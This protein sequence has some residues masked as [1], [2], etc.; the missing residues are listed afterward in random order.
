[1]LLFSDKIVTVQSE[2]KVK[3]LVRQAYKI[4]RPDGRGFGMIRVPFNSHQKI[5]NMRGWCIP[6]QGKDYEVKDKDAIETSLFQI[7]DSELINDVRDKFLQIPAADPGNIVGYEY[8]EEEQP[9]ALQDIWYFQHGIPVREA[10][11]TLQLPPGW[12]YKTTFL[13]A[14]EV[15]PVQSGN[16]WQ[17]SVSDVKALKKEEE[18]PPWRGVAG[19][20]IVSYFPAGGS[21]SGKTF[22]DW[23]QMGSW[24]SQLTRG[25]ADSSPEIKQRVAALTANIPSTLDKM[26]EIARFVQKDVRYVAIELGI[27]GWQPHPSQEVFS[28]RYGDC[29]DKATLLSA[30]LR[31]IGIDSYYVVINTERGSVSPEVQAHLGAFDHAILAIKLPPGMAGPSLYATLQHPKLGTLLFF[32]PT[33]EVTPFGQIGGYLQ[34]NYGLLVGPDGGELVQVPKQPGNMNSINRTAKLTLTP[35]GALTGDF[36]E[37]RV[38]DRAAEQREALRSVTKDADRIKPIETMLSHSLSLFQIT[39]ATV[40]NLQETREPFQ[41]RYSVVAPDYAKTAGGLL[42]VRPRVVGTKSSGL[43][44][45]KEPRQLPVEFGGPSLDTDTFEIILPP[46]YEVDE[47]PP[48]LDLNYSF[49]SYHSKT[50][51]NGSVLRYT[52]SL[53]VKEL[54]VP[55]NK[56]E[57]LR[58]F[59]RRIAGDERNTAVLKPSGSGK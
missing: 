20:M 2:N 58:N 32:D 30:M 39:K 19:Q 14:P 1:M 8:E 13:N 43:L 55:V 53:E 22:G 23:R 44:E 38:G 46:G 59:Y 5:T 11:Y 45:T 49:A 40:I 56:M 17:W 18:M 33:N 48:P 54:S 42:L 15:K 41:Y 31:E 3:T 28:H 16:Q 27:G 50:Q 37:T 25:R 35:Q 29:K 21:V 12:E 4:L 51:A 34:A 57:E 26:R 52:R 24:Y 47:L 7:S 36:E 10:Q 9:Y 6:A